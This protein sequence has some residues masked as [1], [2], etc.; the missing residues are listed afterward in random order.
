ML[1]NSMEQLTGKWM[2]KCFGTSPELLAL[3][4]SVT[5]RVARIVEEMTELAQSEGITRD[6]VVRLVDDV[7]AREIGDPRQEL[8]GVMIC[9]AAYAYT[10]GFSLQ[11]E[12]SAEYRRIGHPDKIEK[13]R[14]RQDT[15]FHVVR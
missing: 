2:E 3:K 15:K 9:L 10:K 5:E 6:E 7:Y 8:G 12:W 1:G 11:D 4:S 14:A 13:I